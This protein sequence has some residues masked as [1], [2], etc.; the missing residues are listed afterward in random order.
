M[1][2]Q[3]GTVVAA[4]LGGNRLC[5][6]CVTRRPAGFCPEIQGGSVERGGLVDSVF[7]SVENRP[8]FREEVVLVAK[9]NGTVLNLGVVE[10][11]PRT[12]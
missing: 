9:E 12:R 8:P 1:N 5:T 2:L 3:R 11:T 6:N 7:R 4:E 10:P